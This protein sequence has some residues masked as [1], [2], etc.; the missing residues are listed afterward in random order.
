MPLPGNKYFNFFALFLRWQISFK[1]I[2]FFCLLFKYK[3]KPQTGTTKTFYLTVTPSCRILLQVW[4]LTG[5]AKGVGKTFLGSTI[6][7]L[8]HGGAEDKGRLLNPRPLDWRWMVSPPQ[9]GRRK[10]TLAI[11]G[12][13]WRN[14]LVLWLLSLTGCQVP[15]GQT[16]LVPDAC[17]GPRLMA[18]SHLHGRPGVLPWQQVENF[19]H[20]RMGVGEG[21]WA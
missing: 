3:A 7:R 20:S 4:P 19:P 16:H 6:M 2:S 12:Q 5:L 9:G 17:R 13:N 18:F 21:V 11:I 14:L 8:G 1:F 15:Q 10:P